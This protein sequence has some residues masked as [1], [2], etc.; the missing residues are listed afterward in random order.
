MQKAVAVPYV[1][2]LILGVA[3]VGLVGIWLVMSGGKFT[4]QSL[5]SSCQSKALQICSK[6]ITGS[7]DL[8]GTECAPITSKI[9]TTCKVL[10]GTC[11]QTSATC[12]TN[13]ECCS[14]SCTGSPK[15]CA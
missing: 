12:N 11:K 1:I 14:D 2:A 4:G 9:T 13:E 15:K 5:E 7:A 3:V 8:T 6:Q 10:L